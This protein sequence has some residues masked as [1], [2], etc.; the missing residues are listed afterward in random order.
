MSESYSTINPCNMC[1]PMGSVLAFRGIEGCMPLFH[2]SQGCA[3]YMRLYLAHHFREPVDIASSALSEK[4]TVYGGSA[5]LKMGL[6][7]LI[8]GYSPRAI[9]VATTCLAETIGDDIVQ[10]IKEFRAEEESSLPIIP[11][12]TPSYSA[13]HEEGYARALQAIVQTLAR[14]TEPGSRTNLIIGSVVSP[15][16]VRYLKDMLTD[17]GFANEFILLPDISETLDAPR[18]ENPPRITEG[19]TPLE[20]VVDTANSC[21]TLTVGG[22]F[23]SNSAGEYLEREFGVPQT[24]LP[25]PIGL[26]DTDLFVSMLEDLIG[27]ALPGKY[28][29]QRGRLLDTLA[30]VH[31]YL[32]GVRVAVYGD[33]DIALGLTRFLCEA[34]A[35][36]AVVATGSSSTRFEAEIRAVSEDA[37][38]LLGADFSQIH[39]QIRKA[40]IDLMLGTSNGRQISRKEGIPLV[41]V[42]LPNH[43]RVGAA[44]QLLIGYEGAAMLADAITNALLDENSRRTD[45]Q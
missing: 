23:Q 21:R 10:I 18:V 4:G 13:S 43:D 7:N 6:K 8:T 38:I 26:K 15:A 5:N 3:T 16:D 1:M 39:D 37:R 25:L 19:G 31:K 32:A 29:A 17:W 28:E 41:R 2:G 40:R 12:S 30:D 20:D 36:P 9:G 11:V 14:R 44:R 34:G 27:I 24:A 45:R 33:S 35:I 22:Q 42:G